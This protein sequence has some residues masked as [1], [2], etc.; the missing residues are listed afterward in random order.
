MDPAAGQPPIA[1]PR[2][3]AHTVRWVVL[4]VAAAVLLPLLVLFGTRLDKDA[5]AV[6]SVLIG[7]PAPQFSLRT[8]DGQTISNAQ[9]AGKPYVVNFWASWCPPCR[10]EHGALRVFWE[11]YRDDGVQLLGVIFQDRSSAARAFQQELG[12]DWPLLED[13]GS[14]TAVDFGLR[15]PPETFVV[16]SQG[17]ITTAFAGALRAGQ[18]EAALAAAE[19]EF[20]G[21]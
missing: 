16:N 17:I 21:R 10:E 18:L 15:A 9:L 13:P 1:A 8:L 19:S 7:K 4:G 11:R 12:G 3:G 2:G 20:A 6:P 5:T 14:E